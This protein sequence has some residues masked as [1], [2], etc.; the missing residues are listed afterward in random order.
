M[1]DDDEDVHNGLESFLSEAR[2][3]IHDDE[4]GVEPTDGARAA[5]DTG[6]TRTSSPG[7]ARSGELDAVQDGTAQAGWENPR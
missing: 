2:S 7:E 4:D 5:A 1:H 3:A 6:I